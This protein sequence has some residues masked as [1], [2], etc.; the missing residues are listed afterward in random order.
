MATNNKDE[1]MHEHCAECEMHHGYHRYF[2]LRWVL[3][4]VIILIVFW[5]GLKIGEFKGY[6][7]SDFG[8]ST[9]FH[10]SGF[11]M[12]PG[13]MNYW[14]QQVPTPDSTTTT[15]KTTTPKK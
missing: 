9:G 6:F 11:R 10:Q 4:I 14:Y 13:M 3:G 15:P 2:F 5:L 7:E 12:G 8:Y 1:H